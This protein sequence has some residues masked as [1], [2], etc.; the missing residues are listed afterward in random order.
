MGP[1][2]ELDL[3][4][5][6]LEMCQPGRTPTLTIDHRGTK[7]A[8][9]KMVE[10]LTKMIGAIGIYLDIRHPDAPMAFEYLAHAGVGSSG[11]WGVWIEVS[12]RARKPD[13]GTVDATNEW[14]AW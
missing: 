3:I 10:T 8:A 6:A 5:Y 9:R 2:D 14:S 4:R 11:M 7:L 12:V 1:N 13:D